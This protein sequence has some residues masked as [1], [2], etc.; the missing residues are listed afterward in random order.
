MS[1]ERPTWGPPEVADVR[2]DSLLGA[3]DEL[4]KRW[5][6]ALL[7]PRPLERAAELSLERFA[8]EAPGI[9][10]SVLRALQSDAELERLRT[11]DVQAGAGAERA[12]PAALVAAADAEELVG[13]VE[14]LRSVLWRALGDALPGLGA[15]TT[16]R[17][18]DRLAYACSLVLASSLA[19]S[20]Y[21]HVEQVLAAPASEDD[22]EP[23]VSEQAPPRAAEAEDEQSDRSPRIEMQDARASVPEQPELED[24]WAFDA[25]DAAEDATYPEEVASE[26]ERHSDDGERFVVLLIEVVDFERLREAESAAALDDLLAATQRALADALGPAERLAAE[27]AARWWLVARGAREAEG[28]ALAE[29]LARSVSAAVAHRRVA[30]KVTI[31]VAVAP[32]DGT[33]A[34]ELAERAEQELYAARSSGLSVLPEGAARATRPALS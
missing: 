29:L 23:R 21:A 26:I 30:L 12:D 5:L 8:R 2:L 24:P 27:G 13:A 15:G 31:G 28:R 10:E 34:R 4:A 32:E 11:H 19:S 7:Q 6:I 9:C 20:P 33:D 1:V 17:L 3:T 14:A 22:A 16:G 25:T 18:A